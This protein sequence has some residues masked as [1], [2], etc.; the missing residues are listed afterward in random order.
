MRVGR[1]VNVCACRRAHP[2]ELYSCPVCPAPCVP[3]PGAFEGRMSRC[4]GRT[5]KVVH[6]KLSFIVI[7]HIHTHGSRGCV[8]AARGARRRDQPRPQG[9]W[10]ASPPRN[11]RNGCHVAA[12]F[13][14]D[15]SPVRPC[16]KM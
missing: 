13:Y 1:C 14:L 4:V 8:G 7:D 5:S 3:V 10:V 16:Q 12:T 15:L 9:G 6:C 11:G 2:G